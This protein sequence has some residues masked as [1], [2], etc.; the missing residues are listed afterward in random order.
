MNSNQLKFAEIFSFLALM[1]FMMF[2]F[3]YQFKEKQTVDSQTEGKISGKY[4]KMTVPE[5]EKELG[6][7]K[8]ENEKL[9]EK[10]KSIDNPIIID[11]EVVKFDFQT[12]TA[13]LSPE[14]KEYIKDTVVPEIEKA[15][16][17]SEGYINTIEVIGHTDGQRVVSTDSNLDN[18]INKVALGQ[19]IT[20]TPGSNADLGLMRAIAVVK[21]LK[22]IKKEGKGL[23]I[24]DEFTLSENQVF[25][26]Y[27]AGQLTNIDGTFAPYNSEP[28]KTRRRIEIRFTKLN[29]NNN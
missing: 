11:N 16:K 1:F 29:Y 22:K 5:L 15:V 10:L 25:R 17:N 13:T 7:F 4:P 20:L 27:S 21:E 19:N 26:A 23:N 14:L 6:R 9:N 12:G 2:I 28:D 8:R 3:V 18:N 24:L